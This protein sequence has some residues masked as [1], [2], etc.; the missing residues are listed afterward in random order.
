MLKQVQNNGFFTWKGVGHL[1]HNKNSTHHSLVVHAREFDQIFSSSQLHSPSKYPSLT[2][3]PL[4]P[5]QT[6]TTSAA[7]LSFSHNSLFLLHL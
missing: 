3:S 2:P 4:K 6:C 1:Y 7:S 5:K